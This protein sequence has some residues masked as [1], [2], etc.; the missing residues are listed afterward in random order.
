ME[1]LQNGV[2]VAIPEELSHTFYSSKL[3]NVKNKQTNFWT[4]PNAILPSIQL[5][6]M[7]IGKQTCIYGK[8]KVCFRINITV[9][10]Y[11]NI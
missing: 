4:R 2:E 11:L 10:A 5:F 9:L 3:W 1:P 6:A 8:I 7:L